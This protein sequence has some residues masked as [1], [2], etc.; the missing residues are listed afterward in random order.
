MELKSVSLAIPNA[1]FFITGSDTNDVPGIDRGSIIWSTPACIAVG[2]TPDCDGETR[3][4]I[5]LSPQVNLGS[6]P[7]F[8]G[9]LETPDRIVS[10][11]IVPGTKVL[12][13]KVPGADTR[14]R[15]WVNHPTQPDNVTIALG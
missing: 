3:I 1:V 12:E 10:V 5:G 8:D 7:V 13:Q 14:V 11:D 15:I 4:I 9:R 2:C 6:Q